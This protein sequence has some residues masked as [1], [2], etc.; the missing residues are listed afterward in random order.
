MEY[1]NESFSAGEAGIVAR[2]SV[3][4]GRCLDLEAFKKTR[5]KMKIRMASG[6][7]GEE[8][9]RHTASLKYCG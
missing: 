8:G 1:P 2:R 7:K 5:K 6:R 9:A 3:D 4:G